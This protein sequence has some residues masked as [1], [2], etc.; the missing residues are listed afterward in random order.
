MLK[1]EQKHWRKIK[2][3]MPQGSLLAPAVLI[4]YI[5]DMPEIA[6]QIT[7]M[8]QKNKNMKL[9]KGTCCRGAVTITSTT[10]TT[11][12]S[13]LMNSECCRYFPGKESAVWLDLCYKSQTWLCLYSHQLLADLVSPKISFL[14]LTKHIS[15]NCQKLRIHRASG[16]QVILKC[17]KFLAWS[18]ADTWM[19]ILG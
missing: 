15:N 19:C 10:S 12:L 2:S 9:N 1:N 14:D 17:R 11:T 4:M 16:N 3:L 18:D 7:G 8:K 5:N 6:N 13:H